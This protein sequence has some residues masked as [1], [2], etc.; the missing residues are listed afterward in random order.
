MYNLPDE[1]IKQMIR[2]SGYYNQKTKKIRA[3]LEFFHNTYNADINEMKQQ[4]LEKLRPQLLNL[5]G[6]GPETADSILLYALD[7]PVF[8]VDAYTRRMLSRH[9]LIDQSADYETI[10]LLFED[11]LDRD[12]HL[13]NEYHALIVNL[14]KDFCGTKPRCE[15]CPLRQFLRDDE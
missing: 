6:I 13:Y 12:V 9:H 2:S 10:R 15:N 3:F 7:K 4:P 5:F 11:N 8:V 14:G 1:K